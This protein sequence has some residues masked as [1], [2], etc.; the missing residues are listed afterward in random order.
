MRLR[1]IVKTS[2]NNPEGHHEG[3][4]YDT[5]LVYVENSLLSDILEKNNSGCYS[6]SSIV[7]VEV[8]SGSG[9]DVMEDKHV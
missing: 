5:F 9:C 1:I 7:G 3:N 6:R 2:H 8:I 4:S